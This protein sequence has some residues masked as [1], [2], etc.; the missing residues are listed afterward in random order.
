MTE[1]VASG[2]QECARCGARIK[3]GL[4]YV[5]STTTRSHYHLYGQCL[6]ERRA[7]ARKKKT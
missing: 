7:A 6:D 5:Y 4:G 1:R 3:A 2:K